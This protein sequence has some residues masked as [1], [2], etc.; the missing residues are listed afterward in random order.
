MGLLEKYRAWRYKRL[1]TIE[2]QL[3]HLRIII[4]MDDRWMA[5]DPKVSA[6][7]Q[8]YLELLSPDWMKKQVEPTP[9]LRKRLGCDP[10]YLQ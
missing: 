4:Q 8:R 10:Q 5:H 7:T 3:E 2:R 6:M 9:E 1:W